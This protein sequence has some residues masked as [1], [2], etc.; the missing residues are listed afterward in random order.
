MRRHRDARR[1]RRRTDGSI[2][3]HPPARRNRPVG[4]FGLARAPVGLP[5]VGARPAGRA[6]RVNRETCAAASR[7]RTYTHTQ[8][9]PTAWDAGR[10]NQVAQPHAAWGATVLE[11]LEL[12]GDEVV[13][14]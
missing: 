2:S 12:Q 14:D 11:R 9:M 1:A 7:T 6:A 10:Y 5:A 8:T 4:R 3:A 13:L